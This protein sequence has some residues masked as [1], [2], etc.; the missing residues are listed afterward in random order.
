LVE[1]GG[2]FLAMS[3]E[4]A[5]CEVGSRLTSGSELLVNVRCAD[6]AGNPVDTFYTATS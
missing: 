4:A 5:R 1:L 6:P 3:P 2:E